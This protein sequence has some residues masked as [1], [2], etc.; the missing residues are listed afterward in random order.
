VSPYVHRTPS[1]AARR[2]GYTV[3]EVLL[4]MTVLAIGASGVMS[5]QK[6]S[7]QGNLDARKTD[8]AANIARMWMDRIEKD[9]MS[10]TNSGDFGNAPLL[11]H[12]NGTWFVPT[13]YLPAA[14]GYASISPGFDILGRD[15]PTAAG[16]PNSVFCVHVREDW[17]AQNASDPADSLIRVELRVVWPRGIVNA[18]APQVCTAGATPATSLDPTLYSTLYAVTAVRANGTQ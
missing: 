18:A 14:S 6:A 4:A 9:A 12:V 7:M 17:L 8:I 5:M 3:V 2:R 10:W 15:V 13:D 16:L 11:G 1:P